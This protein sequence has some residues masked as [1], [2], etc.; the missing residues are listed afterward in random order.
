M[1]GADRTR[2]SLCL[3]RVRFHLQHHSY[4]VLVQACTA[5]EAGKCGCGRWRGGQTRNEMGGEEGAAHAV[6]GVKRR[7]RTCG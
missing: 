3:P 5:W 7:G 4:H 2:A 6:V 1:H